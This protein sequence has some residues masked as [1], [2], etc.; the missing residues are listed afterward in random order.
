MME[1]SD[2][3]ADKT[4][5]DRKTENTEFMR[6]KT[7]LIENET[8]LEAKLTDFLEQYGSW[9]KKMDNELT[10]KIE[11]E[12]FKSFQVNME[13]L[14]KVLQSIVTKLKESADESLFFKKLVQTDP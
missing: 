3:K 1:L 5:V 6:T 2:L 10:Y 9:K 12:A 13:N 11:R 7:Q 4:A 8:R 14:L